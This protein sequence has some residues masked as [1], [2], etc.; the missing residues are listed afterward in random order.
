[1]KV[2]ELVK[3]FKE[4]LNYKQNTEVRIKINEKIYDI[5]NIRIGMN[6]IL[7]VKEG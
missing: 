5:D 4:T 2:K 3:R 7:E 1:M 6:I